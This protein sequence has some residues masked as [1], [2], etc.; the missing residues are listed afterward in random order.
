MP[1]DFEI[2]PLHDILGGP[3]AFYQELDYLA[4][5]ERD[6]A[7]NKTLPTRYTWKTERH[8][9][10][11]EYK[12]IRL[13][14]DIF[15]VI[16]YPL[17]ILVGFI[18]V[19][20][21]IGFSREDATKA[22][23]TILNQDASEQWKFKRLTVE[24]DGYRVDAM[25]VG[26]PSTLSNGRWLL[27]SN[28]N[29][30]LYENK[31]EANGSDLQQILRKIEG[32]AL[33]FNYPGVGASSGF[34]SRQAMVKAY[35]AMLKFLEDKEKGI[36]AKQIIGWGHSIGGGVQ[37]DALK[38]HELKEDIEYVFVKRQTFSDLQTIASALTNRPLG[39]LVKIFGWNISS[40]ESSKKLN[41]PEIIMQTANVQGD[42]EELD[43]SSKIIDD[44]VITAEA[45]L[46][47][48]LLDDK[49]CPREKKGFI[50]MPERH[51]DILRY[52]SFL[53]EK[54]NDF[55]TPLSTNPVVDMFE[56]TD[57][58]EKD[59]KECPKENKGFI[60]MSERHEELINPVFLP[61]NIMAFLIPPD[62]LVIDEDEIPDLVDIDELP[63]S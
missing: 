28:G 19:P 16:V 17:H 40:I 31:F 27:Q 2:P 43:D 51:N 44:G 6:L 45:S 50:G 42:Y 49:E 46:A 5:T 36:G 34:C 26:K 11:T 39:F 61:E 35:R 24:V 23:S 22:R 12:I 37:G 47:K 52:P 48:R 53:A 13:I 62:D 25:I 15:L 1:I 7:E 3:N 58:V 59:D 41:A 29:Y 60:G 56:K 55:L 18:V 21:S 8:I 63:K 54:I 20:A 33:V 10:G 14:K 4:S 9:S 57:L 38:T 32:N 30:E